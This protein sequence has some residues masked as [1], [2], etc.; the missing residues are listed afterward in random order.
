MEIPNKSKKTVITIQYS[1]LVMVAIIVFVLFMSTLLNIDLS[2]Y[3]TSINNVIKIIAAIRIAT[4]YN[5]IIS[6]KN[7]GQE[8]SLEE[9]QFAPYCRIF[10]IRHNNHRYLNIRLQCI[11]SQRTILW[12]SREW[13]VWRSYNINGFNYTFNHNLLR[14]HTNNRSCYIKKE[15]KVLDK[16]TQNIAELKIAVPTIALVIILAVL[17]L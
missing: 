10:F 15:F 11:R 3:Q 7:H 2:R 16:K 1:I 5:K 8:W 9:D 14:N 12:F 6:R 13:L 4:C 17:N